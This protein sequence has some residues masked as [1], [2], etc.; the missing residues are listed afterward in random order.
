MKTN[1]HFLWR[2]DKQQ[3]NLTSSRLV[4]EPESLNSGNHEFH[5]SLQ[6]GKGFA[7]VNMFAPSVLENN[8]TVNPVEGEEA[9]T[10]FTVIC[11]N[12]VNPLRH[13]LFQGKTQVLSSDNYVFTT[14]L[15][16]N[17]DVQV[18][19]QDSY[20]PYF[21]IDLKIKI[22]KSEILNT[23]EEINEVFTSNNDERDLKRMISDE[24][25]SN[26]IVFINVLASRLSI[27]KP[28]EANDI[29]LRTLDLMNELIINQFEDISSIIHT[30]MNLILPINMNHK[31][32]AK[33]AKIFDKVSEVL[34]TQYEEINFSDYIRTTN[35]CLSVINEM[36]EPFETIPPVQNTDSLVSKEYHIEDYKEYGDL[37]FEIFEK[38][39]N[40]EKTSSSMEKIMNGLATWAANLLLPMEILGNIETDNIQFKVVTFDEEVVRNHGNNLRMNS[41]TVRVTLNDKFLSNFG[42]ESSISCGFFNKNPMWWYPDGND[43]N[44]DVVAVSIYK[45]VPRADDTVS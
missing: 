20:G 43:I 8:C 38:L 17:N 32:A 31:A 36:I 1:E 14:K 18:R 22:K 26:T 30:L 23:I 41:T 6:M 34:Q 12:N 10:E 19:I 2:I 5:V 45:R 35:D 11:K 28:A 7:T 25:R 40:L 37:D 24:S 3:L 15:N 9:I 13:T 27:L 44:S 16:A 21:F 39:E 42:S 4:L 29:V 33:C